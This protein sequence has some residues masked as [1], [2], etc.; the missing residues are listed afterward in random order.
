VKISDFI[1]FDKNRYFG[2]AVQA[3]WFYD[4][5]KVEAITES[6]VFHGPKYHGVNAEEISD[7]RYRLH[8]TASYALAL[9]H[10]IQ[11]ID[12]NRFNLTIAGYG[13]G[14]SHLAV[15]LAS[16]LSGHNEELRLTAIECIRSVD[17]AIANEFEQYKGRNLVLVYNGMSNFNLDSETLQLARAALTQHGMDTSILSSLTKQYEQALLFVERTYERYQ[18][19]YLAA[20]QRIPARELKDHIVAHIEDK[21]V[22]SCVNELYYQ[23]NGSYIQQDR[24]ISAGDILN[25]LSQQFCIQNHVFDRIIILFDEFGRYIEYAA[26][27]PAVAGDS[28]LQQVFEAVQ[29]A[30]GTILFDAFIQSDLNTYMSRIGQTSNIVRYVGR[31]EN[32][33]K[34]YLSSNFETILAN[35]LVKQ[36]EQRFQELIH[37]HVK[38]K[39]KQFYQRIYSSFMRW[40]KKAKEKSVWSKQELYDQVILQGCY[41]LHP[42][43]V[44]VLSG[45]SDWMQQRSTIAFTEQMFQ[46]IKN[47]EIS[48]QRLPFVYP[49]DMIDTDLFK[50]MVNSER[51]GLVNSQYCLQYE[52]VMT[53]YGDKFSTAEIKVLRAILIMNLCKFATNDREDTIQATRYCTGMQKDD[54]LQALAELERSHGVIAFDE[55]VKRFDFLEEASGYNDFERVRIRKKLAYLKHNGIIECDDELVEDLKLDQP[56]Q[57]DFAQTNHINSC[58]WRYDKRLVDASKVD[59]STVRD[60]IYMVDEATDGEKAR[61]LLIYLY[62]GKMIDRD[63]VTIQKLCRKYEISKKAILIQLLSD[64]EEKLLQ[65]LIE[66]KTVHSFS[67]SEK[68]RFANFVTDYLSKVTRSARKLIDTMKKERLFVTEQGVTPQKETVRM[69]CRQ[70]FVNVYHSVIPFVFDGF[71]NKPTPQARKNLLELCSRMYDGSL[72]NA[73]MYQSLAP[74]LK[75]RVMTVL[76]TGSRDSWQVLDRNYQ[77]CE[78]QQESVKKIYHEI[79]EKISKNDMP[80]KIGVLFRPYLG[81]PYGLNQ[82]SLTLFVMYMMS[83]FGSRMPVYHNSQLLRKSDLSDLLFRNEKKLIETLPKFSIQLSERTSSDRIEELCKKIIANHEVEQCSALQKQLELLKSESDDLECIRDRIATAD[84]YLKEGKRLYTKIYTETLELE[85]QHLRE[86]KVAFNLLKAIHIFKKIQSKCV[87][88]WIDEDS[89]YQYTAAYCERTGTLLSETHNLLR[90]NFDVFL[91]KMSCTSSQISEFRK[92]YKNAASTLKEIGYTEY[93]QKLIQRIQEVITELEIR[94]KYESALVEID[95]AVSLIGAAN[96]LTYIR[97]GENRETLQGWLRFM[98]ASTDMDQ[99]TWNQYVQCLE[100]AIKKVDD[101]E[102]A[103]LTQAEVLIDCIRKKHCAQPLREFYAKIDSAERMGLPEQYQN[104]FAAAKNEI[105]SYLQY[106]RSIHEDCASLNDLCREYEMVWSKTVCA[107]ACERLI[108]RIKQQL[109]QKRTEWVKNNI[110][111]IQ[112]TIDTFTIQDCINWKTKHQS[113][114]DFLEDADVLALR[115]LETQ[116]DE[117]LH[118][119]NIQGVV[120]MFQKL[121]DSEKKECLRILLDQSNS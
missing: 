108:E 89:E 22:F 98:E 26:A 94:Q 18:D 105:S 77:L 3:N 36:N 55:N 81:A 112:G 102:N 86:I 42:I 87:G 107:N 63:L 38:D 6:Y 31:Y 2:G 50:E 43:T 28:A 68:E 15:A 7:H 29:N 119:M 44:W 33:E 65:L 10:K 115:T 32:S 64:K 66:R 69:L 75:N 9:L 5:E 116:V 78:P 52:A 118:S 37:Y 91:S 95:K 54:V 16:L 117:R 111:A 47:S 84:R 12:G 88:D 49:V 99:K 1:H 100:N 113:Y 34:Y 23:V 93:A 59:E 14:K 101:R 83:Y 46:E 20:F 60:W 40:M 85:E 45:T 90:E 53:K 62:G 11:N 8:D 51:N 114:P 58:E 92:K 104:L 71:E 17:A 121:S 110:T 70:Q 109:K 56:E 39:Y 41:P 96:T 103:I 74:V 80:Q 19:E 13:T 97:C 48:T 24:G 57:T 27:N 4:S 79:V 30:K 73:Q 106:E 61:G 35:L 67:L 72:L 82:Y 76:L 120:S 21:D 25:V